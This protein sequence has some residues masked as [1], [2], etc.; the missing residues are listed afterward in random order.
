LT[1]CLPAP[2]LLACH[3]SRWNSR[4]LVA[5]LSTDIKKSKTKLPSCLFSF[6]RYHDNL[7]SKVVQFLQAVIFC[8]LL[9]ASSS[10]AY[11]SIIC[12]FLFSWWLF[13]PS[14]STHVLQN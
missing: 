4:R 12:K 8:S 13:F 6:K 14:G 2:A 5:L 9:R 11:L 10:C 1:R 7:I 3:H